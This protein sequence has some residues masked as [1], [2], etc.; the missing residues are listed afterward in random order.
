MFMVYAVD[1]SGRAGY[2]TTM[3]FSLNMPYN[4]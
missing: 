4:R 2:S 3:P 1:K